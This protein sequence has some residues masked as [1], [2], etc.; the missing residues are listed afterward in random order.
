MWTK[1]INFLCGINVFKRK[2][3]ILE[4]KNADLERAY[5]EQVQINKE[6]AKDFSSYLQAIQRVCTMNQQ[7]EISRLLT[8]EFLENCCELESLK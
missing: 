7:Y 5:M 2:I 8:V 1:I 3:G 6:L 4:L